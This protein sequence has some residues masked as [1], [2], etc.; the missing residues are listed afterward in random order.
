[1]SA[2][3]FSGSYMD[4]HGSLESSSSRNFRRKIDNILAGNGSISFKQDAQAV[5]STEIKQT[6]NKNFRSSKVKFKVY[7]SL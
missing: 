5:F 7:S 6:N 4:C 2:V 1:M 3:D